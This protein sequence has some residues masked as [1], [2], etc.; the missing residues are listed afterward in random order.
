MTQW[1][2]CNTSVYSKDEADL[3]EALGINLGVKYYDCKISV[4]IDDISSVREVFEPDDKYK[5]IVYMKSGE[6]FYLDIDY[7]ILVKKIAGI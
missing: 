6:T 5:S 2:H 1:I 7:S 4:R 3:G